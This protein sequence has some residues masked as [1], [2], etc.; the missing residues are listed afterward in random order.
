MNKN[1]LLALGIII[2]LLTAVG[3]YMASSYKTTISITNLPSSSSNE[4]TLEVKVLMN[5]GPLGG[6]SPLSDAYVE[7]YNSQ[8]YYVAANFTN[9]QGVAIFH[10]PPG[11]YKVFVTQ[12]HCSVNVSLTSSKEVT[13]SY[14]YLYAP[15]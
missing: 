7:I 5:Y 1:L 13:I 2:L 15:K 4:E 12:L 10:L 6:V 3:V 8:G 11:N 14:A 9:S